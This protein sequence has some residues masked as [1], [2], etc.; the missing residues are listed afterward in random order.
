MSSGPAVSGPAENT[1]CFNGDDKFQT[2]VSR[3]R[4]REFRRIVVRYISHRL[5][6]RTRVP[7]C[8]DE[9]ILIVIRSDNRQTRQTRDDHREALRL[10]HCYYFAETALKACGGREIRAN[11]NLTFYSFIYSFRRLCAIMA[12]QQQQQQCSFTRLVDPRKS[13]A[14]QSADPI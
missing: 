1:V 8:R 11:Q 4:V 2:D 12:Y 14:R 5:F 10:R 6:A 7:L 13:R 9:F 3:T